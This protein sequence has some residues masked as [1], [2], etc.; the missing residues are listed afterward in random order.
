M[1]EGDGAQ[2][3]AHEPTLVGVTNPLFLSKRIPGLNVLVLAPAPDAPPMQPVASPGSA[4]SGNGFLLPTVSSTA[5]ALTTMLRVSSGKTP[6]SALSAD[7]HGLWMSY[8][9]TCTGGNRGVL[10]KLKRTETRRLNRSLSRGTSH[11]AG[12]LRAHFYALTTAFLSPFALFCGARP[13]WDAQAAAVRSPPAS[14]L[15]SG[16]CMISL[17]LV[18]TV[19]EARMYRPTC[20]AQQAQR[21]LVTSMLRRLRPKQPPR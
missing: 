20:R 21:L 2:H 5:S 9:G 17:V 3:S 14:C 7:Q 13:P 16:A 4:S 15:C 12:A 10:G 18:V 8:E 1:Q 6:A 11:N 19:G